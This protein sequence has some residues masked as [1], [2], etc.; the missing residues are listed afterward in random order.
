[1][2]IKAD[3]SE[4]R[5]HHLVLSLIIIRLSIVLM[6]AGSL[7]AMPNVSSRQLS[8]HQS[9]FYCLVHLGM[10]T[11]VNREWG[12]GDESPD[13]F[14]PTAFDADQIVG[15]AKSAG[16]RG[17]VLVCKHH[18]GFCIWPSKYTEHSV[19]H[20]PWRNGNGDVV[21]EI[22]DASRKEG[23]KFGVYLSPWDRNHK[24]YGHP[25]YVTYYRNLLR[26]LLTNYG[27]IFIAWFDGACG[28]D[29]Y[30]GG[31]REKRRV[32]GRTYYGWPE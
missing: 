1:M 7:P 23:L 8:W 12:M 27:D 20:S 10:N 22:S 28:G 21:K 5:A 25:E 16:M 31:T 2:K 3:F 4:F 26:E 15:V 19:K 9:E 13:L 29:G 17:L 32:D 18:D 11:F 24:D 30:Y 6:H 14:N